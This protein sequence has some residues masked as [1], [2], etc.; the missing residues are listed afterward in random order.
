MTIIKTV[1][2][3]CTGIDIKCYVM[4]DKEI[5]ADKTDIDHLIQKHDGILPRR[6]V[7]EFFEKIKELRT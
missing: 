7:N 2:I 6:E 4:K 3:S 5:H 1:V